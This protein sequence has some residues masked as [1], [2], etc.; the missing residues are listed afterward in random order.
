MMEGVKGTVKLNDIPKTRAGRFY[1]A[2]LQSDRR[3]QTHAR[4]H[5]HT[6]SCM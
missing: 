6:S 3:C 5:A 2:D 4:A 1:I